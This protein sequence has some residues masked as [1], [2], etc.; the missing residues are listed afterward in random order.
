MQIENNKNNTIMRFPG[1]QPQWNQWL[2]TQKIVK[3]KRQNR[4]VKD[5][6]PPITLLKSK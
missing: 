5:N 3:F 1:K 2:S 6:P 4:Q